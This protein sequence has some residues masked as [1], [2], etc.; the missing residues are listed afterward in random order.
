MF[1]KFFVTLLV[2][3]TVYV[4]GKKTEKQIK[5]TNNVESYIRELEIDIS[6]LDLTSSKLYHFYKGSN[7]LKHL[8][9]SSNF[10]RVLYNMRMLRVYDNESY[11][12]TVAY[13]EYFLKLHF[14]V[15]IGKYDYNLY[16]PVLVD[17]R[18]H[19]LD[20]MYSIIYNIP[21]YSTVKDVGDMDEY[22]LNCIYVVQS[23]SVKYIQVLDNKYGNYRY[24]TAP[25]VEFD[26]TKDYLYNML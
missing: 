24:T 26:Y 4:L 13:L 12:K 11:L 19:I 15:M 2:A 5:E 18:N 17:L 25:P 20:L 8:I 10:N 14:N 21:K 23:T 3:I 9:R 6:T 7:S 16:R 22:L 1:Q